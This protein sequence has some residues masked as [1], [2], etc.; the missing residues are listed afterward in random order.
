MPRLK[1]QIKIALTLAAISVFSLS[2]TEA[3]LVTFTDDGVNTTI[4]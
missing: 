1:K 2:E 4:T 3:A